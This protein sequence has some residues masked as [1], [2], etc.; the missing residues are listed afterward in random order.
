MESGGIW[1]AAGTS[2]G[3]GDKTGRG[4]EGGAIPKGHR[5]PILTVDGRLSAE[6][7]GVGDGTAQLEDIPPPSRDNVPSSPGWGTGGF[8]LYT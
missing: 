8:P 5:G 1:P 3:G 4:G 6:D 2:F 7:G